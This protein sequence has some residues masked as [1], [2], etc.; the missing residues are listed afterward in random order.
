VSRTD[1]ALL[2]SVHTE[3]LEVGTKPLNTDTGT[4]SKVE[5]FAPDDLST[6]D[7]ASMRPF[8]GALVPS[9]TSKP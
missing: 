9:R 5:L 8:K 1:L 6:P 2:D 3:A 7:R 4:V